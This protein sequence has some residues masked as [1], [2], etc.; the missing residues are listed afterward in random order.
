MT[1]R[2]IIRSRAPLRLGLAGGGTDIGSYSDKFGGCV[3]NSTVS[4]FAY[5]NLEPRSDS[6]II[7]ESLSC[8]IFC[9]ASNLIENRFLI[10][11]DIN[12]YIF[13]NSWAP[14]INFI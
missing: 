2:K 9:I 5:A 13:N 11:N 8:G 4:M 6:K 1:S 10:K 14:T 7:L 12:G 3:L